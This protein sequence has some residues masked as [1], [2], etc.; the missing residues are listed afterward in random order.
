VLPTIYGAVMLASRIGTNI[1]TA[2]LPVSSRTCLGTAR[3]P[4]TIYYPSTKKEWRR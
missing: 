4:I 1:R 3:T 2:L